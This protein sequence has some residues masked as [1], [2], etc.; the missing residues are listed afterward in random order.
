M[1]AT[2]SQLSDLAQ[3][4]TRHE[5]ELATLRK[6]LEGRLADLHRRREDLRT[7]LRDVEAEIETARA[8]GPQRPKAAPAPKKVSKP[9]VPPPAQPTASAFPSLP[10]F[11]VEL[12]RE[13]KVQPVTLGYL[14]QEVV[15]RQFPTQ[16]K[17]VADMVSTR[18]S[19][20]VKRGRLRRGSA[21]GGLLLAASANGKQAA[22]S[23]PIVRRPKPAGRKPKAKTAPS[24]KGSSSPGAAGASQPPLR[25]VVL[26]VLKKAGRTLSVQEIVE[27]VQQ[28]GYQSSSK[29]LK[30]LIWA[31]T[32]KYSEVERD[33]KGGYRLTKKG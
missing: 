22:A 30:D 25:A 17:H 23:K 4:I 13:A 12:V 29:S 28:A 24:S 14:Q 3:R 26:A 32:G 2:T 5:A 11:L 18:V 16:S 8:N 33:P 9:T 19:E 7:E 10:A 31:H 20:L 6:Q 27:G 21:S 15:R 1:A